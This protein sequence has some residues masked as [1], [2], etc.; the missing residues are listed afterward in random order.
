MK[1]KVKNK[2]GNEEKFWFINFLVKETLT[3]IIFLTL[4][5]SQINNTK[6]LDFD[7]FL[8]GVYTQ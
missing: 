6:Y 1:K 8:T 7:I 5:H 2:D 4:K 3:K